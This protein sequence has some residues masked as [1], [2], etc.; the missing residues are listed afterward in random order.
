MNTCDSHIKVS[1]V[2]FEFRLN[3][4][5]CDFTHPLNKRYIYVTLPPLTRCMITAALAAD[6][7]LALRSLTCDMLH[8][9]CTSV[10]FSAGPAVVSF[11]A[12]HSANCCRACFYAPHTLGRCQ[13]AFT[14]LAVFHP[15]HPVFTL[16]A[17]MCCR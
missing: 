7:I 12:R 17:R 16:C 11:H 5:H 2:Q 13:S 4:T 15:N 3:P 9:A 10:Q 1:L 8:T 6:A 14:R